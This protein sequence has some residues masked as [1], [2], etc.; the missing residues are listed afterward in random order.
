M[1]DFDTPT[2]GS[3]ATR[4]RDFDTPT[5]GSAATRVRDFDTPTLGSAAT[6]VRDFDT[7]PSATLNQRDFGALNPREHVNQKGQCGGTVFG[8]VLE[9]LCSAPGSE[10]DALHVTNLEPVSQMQKPH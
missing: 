3:A 4:V 5:L 2:L 8:K 1:R 6:R 10:P 7:L 9:G